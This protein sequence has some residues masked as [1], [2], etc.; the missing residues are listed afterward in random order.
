M[1]GID[2]QFR[3]DG[4]VTASEVA[5][6]IGCA[7]STVHRNIIE[8]KYPG[9]RIGRGWYIDI[10]ALAKQYPEGTTVHA[11]LMKLADLVAHPVRSSTKRAS[12]M[13]PKRSGAFAAVRP[14]ASKK[15]GTT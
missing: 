9:E 11:S 13:P 1:R 7:I 14:G 5:Q 3:N 4:Y 6:A 12:V 10:H 15:T 2:A 8:G